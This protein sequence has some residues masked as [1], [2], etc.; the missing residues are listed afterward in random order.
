VTID[1]QLTDLIRRM[2]D[3]D[4]AAGESV[5]TACAAR[6]RR[7][8]S[9]LLAKERCTGFHAS[10]LLQETLV[11]KVTGDR[12]KT[13]VASREHFFSLIAAGMRQVLTDRGRARSAQKRQA[14]P[15]EELLGSLRPASNPR[16]ADLA[17]CLQRLERLDPHGRELIRY[18]FEHGL[19]WEELAEVTGRPVGQLRAECDYVVTWLKDQLR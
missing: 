4:R 16:L 19:T 10:D 8:S 6:L 13:R 17:I 5:F 2:Q 9:A 3:G 12:L 18:K 7:M 14:P 11:Q 15:V 1:S